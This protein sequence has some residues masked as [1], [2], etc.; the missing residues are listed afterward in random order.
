MKAHY[1]LLMNRLRNE[2][3]SLKTIDLDNGQFESELDDNVFYPACLVSINVPD[4]QNQGDGTQEGNAIITVK[5]A[6]AQYTRT[7]QGQNNVP[8][9]DGLEFMDLVDSVHNALNNWQILT[10]AP[11]L[12][13]T[14]SLMR[15]SNDL[16]PK[17]SAVWLE[18]MTY[19]CWIVD[20]AFDPNT[21][22]V[23]AAPV[24]LDIQQDP[25]LI[26]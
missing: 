23:D 15:T 8:G 11:E 21:N 19:A 22:Y 3:A 17:R 25:N 12:Q 26:S 24:E 20:R 1:H 5:V 13:L 10:S 14:G 7:A 16:Q 18:V 6:A 2:V 9:F 4:W